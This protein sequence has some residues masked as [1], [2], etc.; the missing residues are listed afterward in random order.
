MKWEKFAGLLQVDGELTHN[1]IMKSC[2]ILGIH[3]KEV[4]FYPVWVKLLY[5]QKLNMAKFK[6]AMTAII[7]MES[8]STATDW[9]RTHW[10]LTFRTAV[11]HPRWLDCEFS[12]SWVCAA[13]TGSWNGGKNHTRRYRFLCKKTKE[14]K[15]GRASL[16][17]AFT[18]HWPPLC[19]LFFPPNWSQL[20]VKT[21]TL[22]HASWRR[23][24]SRNAAAQWERE[25]SRSRL[26]GKTVTWARRNRLFLFCILSWRS[27]LGQEACAAA[28]WTSGTCVRGVWWG[29]SLL[30]PSASLRTD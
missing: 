20:E 24:H 7:R 27:V 21:I 4:F 2:A 18:A 6:M 10:P 25:S 28:L 3:H 11:R 8:G 22:C 5:R 9:L 16:P 23:W 13:A 1:L 26:V 17:A 12:F 29:A 15:L 19:R 30:P 14:E